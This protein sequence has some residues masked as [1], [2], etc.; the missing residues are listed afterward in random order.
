MPRA[1]T[2]RLALRSTAA[3]LAAAALLGT[4]AATGQA[5]PVPRASERAA[6]KQ[7]LQ[8]VV[9]TGSSAALGEVRQDGR[10]IWRG[11]AGVADLATGEPVPAR[12][13]FRIGSVTKTLVATVVLQLAG[14][15]RLSLDDTV[16]HLLPG[17]VPNGGGITLRQLLNHTSGLFNYTDA[18]GIDPQTEDQWRAWLAG[19]RWHTYTSADL[20]ALATT[21]APYF[22]PGQGW[23]YSNTNYLL[24][25]MIV[26]KVTGNP[27]QEEVEERIVEP[28]G[29]RDTSMPG[30]STRL[31]GP[32]A[33][34][35]VKLSTGPV[36]VTELDPSVLSAAGSGISSAADLDRFIAA[37]L[38]GEL[39]EP[40]QLAEMTRTVEAGPGRAWGLG[41]ARFD[42]PCGAFWGHSGDLPGYSTML[43]GSADGHRRFTLSY[44]PYDHTDPGA[45][46]GAVTAFLATAACGPTR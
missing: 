34:G 23:H 21:R 36:D 9:D 30:L 11:G 16:E 29:L 1:R 32:H 33:H 45:A 18:P 10:T 3:L 14:E 8:G 35:Y 39:L 46:K 6:L 13:R 41:L 2:R 27:W 40:A 38:G 20:L 24:A 19:P 44:N 43:A 25:G 37:L 17:A 28:L 4:S 31:P 42:T 12:A 15:R 5:A 7:A 22:P 26:E